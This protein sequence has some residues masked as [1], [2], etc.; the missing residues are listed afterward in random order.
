MRYP[1]DKCEYA[2]TLARYLKIHIERKHVG[3][4]Y[5]CN[6]CEYMEL[7]GN[8]LKQHIKRMHGG[9]RYGAPWDMYG[10]LGK[11]LQHL[12]VF[13][14]IDAN[15]RQ[16]GLQRFVKTHQFKQNNPQTILFNEKRAVENQ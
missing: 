1:C 7:R 11:E 13:S 9:V 12:A 15:K 10:D 5:P 4:R 6:K 3:V 16:I 14:L 2:A 8:G